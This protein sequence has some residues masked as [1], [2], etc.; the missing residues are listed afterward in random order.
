MEDLRDVYRQLKPPEVNAAEG[1]VFNSRPVQGRDQWHTAKS[2]TGLPAILVRVDSALGC[3]R[4]LAVSLEN[5]R[6]EH[7]VRCSLIRPDGGIEVGR[8]SIIQCLSVDTEIQDCFL[9]T[10]G[11]AL[12]GM[13]SRI[14]AGE[15]TDLVDRLVV[16]FQ[17]IRRPPERTFRGLWAELFVILAGAD[18]RMMIDAWHNQPTEHFDFGREDER[19]EVKSSATRSR[20]H[21]FSFE[22]VYPPS[23]VSV[24]IASVYVEDQT[25]GRTLGDLW[26]S[27]VDLVPSAEARLK[28]ERVCAQSLGQF[29][30]TGRAFSGDWNLAVESLSFYRVT[31]IPRPS[32]GCPPGV[33]QLRFRSDLNMADP[34]DPTHLGEFHRCCLGLVT[35][36]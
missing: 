15:L 10:I 27:V 21:F 3:D 23:R 33:S 19:L 24:L 22:Q 26:D 20:D 18:P 2:A 36:S 14:G 30:G 13:E 8:Y 6:V 5:L 25:N 34:V 12:M 11:G 16:L 17:L 31:D 9:R 32:P 35:P 28:V 29:L 7:N 4:P 1:E